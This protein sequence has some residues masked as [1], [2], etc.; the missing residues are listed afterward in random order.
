MVV[1]PFPTE[2]KMW[3]TIWKI[4]NFPKTLFLYLSLHP[5]DPKFAQNCS[6]NYFQDNGQFLFLAKFKMVAGIHYRL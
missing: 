6:V 1:N 5:K 2:F 4:N 3:A